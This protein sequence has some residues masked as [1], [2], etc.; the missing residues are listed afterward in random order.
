MFNRALRPKKL[1]KMACPA[2]EFRN[3]EPKWV[4]TSQVKAK[5]WPYWCWWTIVMRPPDNRNISHLLRLAARQQKYLY[6]SNCRPPEKI[7]KTGC[8]A[9]KLR[10]FGPPETSGVRSTRPYIKP[11]L[12]VALTNPLQ[13][14]LLKPLLPTTPNPLQ[15]I[16]LELFQPRSPTPC[17]LNQWNPKGPDPITKTCIPLTYKNLYPTTLLYTFTHNLSMFAHCNLPTYHPLHALVRHRLRN[18]HDV[19]HVLP[20]PF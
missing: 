6:F 5:K 3:F 8:R 2:Y 14:K 17:K 12:V 11:L 13:S 10:F 19:R 9:P 18:F 7:K 15:V 20:I 1:K 4:K 16:P